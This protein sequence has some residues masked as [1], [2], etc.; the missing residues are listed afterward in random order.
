MAFITDIDCKECGVT[1]NEV[2]D[3]SG[4]CA[5]CR[6]KIADRMRRLHF[7]GLKGLTIE[8]RLERVEIELYDLHIDKRLSRLESKTATY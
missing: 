1:K 3:N 6:K 8:E 2:I 4:V 5:E 7:A